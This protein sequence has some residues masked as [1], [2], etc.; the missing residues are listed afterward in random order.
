MRELVFSPV[1]KDLKFPALKLV[2]VPVPT[3]LA[4]NIAAPEIALD[5]LVGAELYVT[6]HFKLI[7]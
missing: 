1:L 5:W 7:S 4:G 6:F 3:Y 2:T